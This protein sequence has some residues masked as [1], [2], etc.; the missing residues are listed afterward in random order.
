MKKYAFLMAILMVGCVNPIQ[1]TTK[2]MTAQKQTTLADFDVCVD[3]YDEARLEDL[4]FEK[5][6]QA[7]QFFPKL[8]DKDNAPVPKYNDANFNMMCG[9][10][11][12]TGNISTS[13]KQGKTWV[14]IQT[15]GD[16]TLQ[17]EKDACSVDEGFYHNGL[18]GQNGETI[19]LKYGYIFYIGKDGAVNAYKISSF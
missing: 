12:L 17:S 11:A 16:L 9:G 3:V 5:T 7:L 10:T 13:P 19:I 15:C 8:L 14:E 2:P 4:Y 6:K 18:K 1:N